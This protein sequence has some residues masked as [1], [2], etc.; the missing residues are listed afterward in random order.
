M[1]CILIGRTCDCM[2]EGLPMV[3]EFLLFFLS[4]DIFPAFLDQ[5]N[6]TIYVSPRALLMM[7]PLLSV[8]SQ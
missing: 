3:T 8:P 1:L 5:A 2:N 7:K 6:I 4:P